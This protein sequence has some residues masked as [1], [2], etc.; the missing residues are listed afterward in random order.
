[1]RIYLP[2]TAAGA[3]QLA[4][5]RQMDAP[6]AAFAVT[7]QLRTSSGVDDEEELEYL[8]LS[9]GAIS[10]GTDLVVAAD[11]ESGD[12]TYGVEADVT[13]TAPVRLRQIVSL[14]VLDDIAAHRTRAAE[15]NSDEI[16]ELQWF[17]VTELDVVLGLLDDLPDTGDEAAT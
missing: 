16:P 7:P 14:H 10:P 8:A 4:Q 13:V 5:R 9:E 11:I 6:V 3:R 2:L 12:L 15:R 1:M 17:D